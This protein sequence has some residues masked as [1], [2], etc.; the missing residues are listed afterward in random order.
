MALQVAHH[1][2]DGGLGDVDQRRRRAH[3]AGQDDGAEG[4]DL[5]GIEATHG[6][7]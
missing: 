5:A 7:L 1:A 4:F 6:P 3:A 2:A